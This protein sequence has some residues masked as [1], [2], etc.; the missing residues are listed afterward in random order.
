MAYRD[1]PFSNPQHPLIATNDPGAAT[2]PAR[3]VT[4]ENKRVYRPRQPLP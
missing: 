3:T 1:R 4:G 2:P